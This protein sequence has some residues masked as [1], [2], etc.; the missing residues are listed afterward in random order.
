MATTD[1]DRR[2]TYVN[3]PARLLL[4]KSFGELER[5]ALED[6]FAPESRHIA[7]DAWEDMIAN[8]STHGL[9][10]LVF[11]DGGQLELAYWGLAEPCPGKYLLAAAPAAWDR[12]ELQRVL[13]ADAEPAAELTEREVEVLCLV[14][15]GH[16]S[17]GIAE[18]LVISESTVKTHL[19]HVYEK[20]A[21]ADRAAAVARAMRL[22]LIS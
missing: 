10:S 6:V 8:G 15:D 1:G 21:V 2:F 14:A 18:L 7:L 5:L 17:R 20:L 16:S 4:R 11:G 12:D 13:A 9:R 19:A 22:G 3:R